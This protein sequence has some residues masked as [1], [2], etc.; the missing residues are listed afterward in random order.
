MNTACLLHM[1][2]EGKHVCSAHLTRD[3]ARHA[4]EELKRETIWSELDL[5]ARLYRHDLRIHSDRTGGQILFISTAAIDHRELNGYE[6]DL[7]VC[8]ESNS[9]PRE[10]WDR[11]KTRERR[12][13]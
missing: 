7:V 11:L 9:L 6:F 1:L 10:T 4:Y 8:N 3:R 12:A 5:K 13:P 2:T